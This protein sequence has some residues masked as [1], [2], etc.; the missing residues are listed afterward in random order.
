MLLFVEEHVSSRANW[1][2]PPMPPL[3]SPLG[4]LYLGIYSTW[5]I[6]GDNMAEGDR[7]KAELIQ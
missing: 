1:G 5:V 7:C 3:V 4:I 6:L 2:L